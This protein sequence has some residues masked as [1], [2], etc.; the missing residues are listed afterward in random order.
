MIQVWPGLLGKRKRLVIV[1]SPLLSP[2]SRFLATLATPRM[3]VRT[4][5]TPPPIGSDRISWGPLL[6]LGDRRR[7]QGR[8][9]TKRKMMVMTEKKEGRKEVEREGLRGRKRDV[10]AIKIE[11]GGGREKRRFFALLL[12][13]FA[14]SSL[15]AS[16]EK[17]E[18]EES[19]G[20]WRRQQFAK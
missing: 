18:R 11:Q 19:S 6:Y 15:S 8:R 7:I 1:P 9:T 2:L 13:Q 16:L 3:Y 20:H 10:R 5:S 4:R 12:S 17:R 14:S